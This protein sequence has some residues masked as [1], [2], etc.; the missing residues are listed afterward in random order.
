MRTYVSCNCRYC[1]RCTTAV[2]RLHKDTAHRAMRRASKEAI[3]KGTDAPVSIS[4]GYK[5]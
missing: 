4:T 1:R 2:K 3:R 5:D